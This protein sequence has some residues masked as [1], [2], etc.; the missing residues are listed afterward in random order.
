MKPKGEVPGNRDHL[1][2]K[3]SN[4]FEIGH[5][6]FEFLLDFGQIS[7]DG[8]DVKFHNRIIVNP[9]YAKALLG[10]LQDSILRYEEEF[11][12]I[13]EIAGINIQ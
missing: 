4:Y 13:P 12:A 3:Y 6:A 5:N 10:I 1:D 7:P 9:S 2:G 8:E 11:E